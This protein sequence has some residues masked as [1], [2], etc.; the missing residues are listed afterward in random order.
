[1]QEISFHT[2]QT[3]YNRLRYRLSPTPLIYSHALSEALGKAIWLKCEQFQVTGSFKARG[4][5]NWIETATE[6]ELCHGLIALSAGNHAL[7]L[8]WAAAIRDV[9]LTV[10]MPEGS[11][12]YKV[13]NARAL[14]AEVILH[15][16]INAAMA[17]TEKLQRQT[18]RTFVPPFDNE[19]IIAGQGTVGLEIMEQLPLT[20]RIVCP[21]GGGGLISGVGTVAKAVSRDI[22]V[23]GVEPAGAATLK[24]AWENG[25]P[26]RLEK[27]DTIAASLAASL[28]GDITYR[29]SRQVVDELI[30]LDEDA[31]RFG[32]R[33]SLERCKLMAEPGSV[34]PVAAVM[35]GRIPLPGTAPTVLVISGGNMDLD[36]LK[37]IA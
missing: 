22:E 16:D 4:A 23:I 21:V 31:I 17:H 6:D 7:G 35:K 34:L 28:A 24:T 18:R 14:G 10:V 36:Q 8:A 11:S 25:E 9:S 20:G 30:T 2:I 37:V 27:V 26:T 15:G 5:L 29:V 32:M 13:R 19:R 3:A 33:E 1:M 12:P